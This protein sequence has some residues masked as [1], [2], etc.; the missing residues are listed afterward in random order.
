[1]REVAA[2]DPSCRHLSSWPS[3]GSCLPAFH[4]LLDT[5]QPQIAIRV[6]D[7]I[8]VSELSD[9]TVGAHDRHVCRLGE[10]GH[11]SIRATGSR[12]ERSGDA[13]G[14]E[15]LQHPLIETGEQV[16]ASLQNLSLE[17]PSAGVSVDVLECRIAEIPEPARV[18]HAE[19]HVRGKL[20]R[21][22]PQSFDD[23][24]CAPTGPEDDEWSCRRRM[25]TRVCGGL[26][27][28]LREEG[29]R[30]D[31]PASPRRP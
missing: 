31:R 4:Q 6:V 24:L 1:M 29:N 19:G 9:K 27:N 5:D 12:K 7:V 15:N 10:F 23:G 2:N 14:Q 21:E 20:V 28:S 13:W 22:S 17:R 16:L 30:P 11:V 26:K 8:R 3:L 25:C 18:H